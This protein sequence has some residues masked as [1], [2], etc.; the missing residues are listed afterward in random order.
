MSYENVG[1][2]EKFDTIKVEK[3]KK[4]WKITQDFSMKICTLANNEKLRK[5]GGSRF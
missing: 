5:M 4:K 2:I 3:V 1:K